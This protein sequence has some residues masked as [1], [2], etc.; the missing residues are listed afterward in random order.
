MRSVSYGQPGNDPRH[1]Y[2][3]TVGQAA[4]ATGALPVEDQWPQKVVGGFGFGHQPSS[5][6]CERT[7][8]CGSLPRNLVGN[9]T[10]KPD[11]TAYYGHSGTHYGHHSGTRSQLAYDK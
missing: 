3:G 8:K 9:C 1:E 4:P 11:G 5:D 10:V 6:T 7:R 2:P